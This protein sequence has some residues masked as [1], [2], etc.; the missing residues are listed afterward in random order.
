MGGRRKER[1][2]FCVETCGQM[3]WQASDSRVI[4]RWGSVMF[5]LWW[6]EGGGYITTHDRREIHGQ[7]SGQHFI[8]IKMAKIELMIFCFDALHFFQNIC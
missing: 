4:T 7:A 3:P 1:G 6:G 5:L 2:A 8:Y